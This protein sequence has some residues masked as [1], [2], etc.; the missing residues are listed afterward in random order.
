MIPEGK[1]YKIELQFTP[2][3][4]RNVSDVRWHHTQKHQMLKDGSCIVTFEVDG[5]NEITWW[6]LGYGD[7]VIVRKPAALRK[8]LIQVYNSALQRNSSTPRA[9][10][11]H[12]QPLPDIQIMKIKQTRQKET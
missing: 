2:K 5:L 7:Q 3:V 9:S 12:D 11:T 8:K 4:G 1:I 6:L 10:D